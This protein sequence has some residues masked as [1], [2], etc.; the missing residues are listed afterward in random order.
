MRSSSPTTGVRV[1]TEVITETLRER[2]HSLIWW[3]LGIVGLIGVTVAFYPSVKGS[4]GLSDYAQDLPEGLRGLFVGGEIDITS[5]PGYLN[6]QVFAMTAPLLLL[7]FAI[8]TGASAVAGEEERGTLDLLLA[9]PLRRS[10]FVLQRFVATGVLVIILSAVLFATV[11][12]ASALVDLEIG[13]DDL[14]AACGSNALLAIL[15]GALALTSGAVLPGR[16][17]AIGIATALAVAAW[18]LDGLGRAIDW[19]DPFRPLSPFYQAIATDPL[20][21]GVPWGSWALLAGLIC[22]L[23]VVAV[24]GLN[25]RDLRQ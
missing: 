13:I 7:I 16:G 1:R 18:M 4:T 5:G 6:S 12:I 20:R 22:A 25:R 10:S 9:H 14:L 11:A 2:R 24:L 23:A 15:F 8:G 17:Q 21:D 3:T 19:L